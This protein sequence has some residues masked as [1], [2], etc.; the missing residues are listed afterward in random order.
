MGV[1]CGLLHAS[2]ATDH[3]PVVLAAAAR[4]WA[5][6]T[7][8]EVQVVGAATTVRRGR[9]IEPVRTAVDN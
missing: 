8:T 9:P 3:P 7:A 2:D 1:F 5:D 4:A 6:V